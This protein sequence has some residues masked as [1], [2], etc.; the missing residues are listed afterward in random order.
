MDLDDLTIIE[1]LDPQQMLVEIDSL[2][3]QLEGAWNLGAELPLPFKGDFKQIVISGM[4]GSAIGADLM[5]AYSSPLCH[6]PIIVWRDYGLPTFAKGPDTLLVAAS[7]SGNTEETLSAFNRGVESGTM[8]LAI[9]T[10][11]ELAKQAENKGYPLW[12]FEHHGQPRA[13]V[14]YSFGLLLAAIARLGLIPDPSEEVQNTVKEMHDQA[15][16]INARIPTVNNPA[17]RMA[18]QL[19]DRIPLIIGADLLAP[20]AR[21]WRTQISEL[22][23]AVA[24]FEE[25]PEADHNMLAGIQNPEQLFGSS[26]VVFLSA[27]MNHPRNLLRLEKTR[28]MMMVGGFNTDMIPAPGSNRLSQQ[29]TSLHFGDY[30]AF[31]LAIAYGVDPTPVTMLQELKAIMKEH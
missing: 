9:T 2:P 24:Q 11:G 20:V 25:I 21:R 7:H 13:A 15:R 30:V 18:G 12:D 29:W 8:I 23:K 10:G 19:I 17:K 22:A 6:V 31:Y 16:G 14:G 5:A 3:D 1:S 4:G 26:M 28:E 27:S